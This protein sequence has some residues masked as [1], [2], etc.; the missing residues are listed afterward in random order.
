M[1]LACDVLP[2]SAF[3]STNLNNKIDSFSDL[4]DRIKRALGY[5][6]ITLE[7]HQD[8]LFQKSVPY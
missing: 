3:Q 1:A 6:L 7:V 5:P 2:V 4:S 8:Q